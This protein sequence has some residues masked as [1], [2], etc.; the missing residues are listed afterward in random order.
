MC[1]SIPCAAAPPHGHASGSTC[2]MSPRNNGHCRKLQTQT[3]IPHV[4]GG[5]VGRRRRQ[6]SKAHLPCGKIAASSCGRNDFK[7]GIGTIAGLFVRSPSA[8]LRRVPE[9]ISLHVIVSNFYNQFRPQRFPRQIFALAP[10]TLSAGHS[11]HTFIIL[12]RCTQPK[13]STDGLSTRL[14]DKA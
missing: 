10:A 12:G 13:P 5:S 8:E 14:F 11:L 4:S 2:V 6:T 9:A 3:M 1:S 7:L